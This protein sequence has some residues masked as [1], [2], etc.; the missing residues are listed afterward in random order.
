MNERTVRAAAAAAA[1]T[2]AACVHPG[3]GGAPPLRRQIMDHVAAYIRSLPCSDRLWPCYSVL[4]I[5]ER[6]VDPDPEECPAARNGVAALPYRAPLVDEAVRDVMR[7]NLDDGLRLRFSLTA[8]WMLALGKSASDC[9]PGVDMTLHDL[10][11]RVPPLSGRLVEEIG[12]RLGCRDCRAG[13]AGPAVSEPVLE[14]LL[15]R[16][17]EGFKARGFLWRGLP[18]LR[19]VPDTDPLLAVAVAHA[20]AY[21]EDVPEAGKVRCELEAMGGSVRP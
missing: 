18:A 13:I 4:R 15:A 5:A 20:A 9:D 7:A 16:L 21:I 3:T 12:D 19:A 11:W 2:A 14:A 8:L 1:I 10:F 17:H 6:G